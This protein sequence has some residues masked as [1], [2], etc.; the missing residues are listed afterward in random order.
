ML[1]PIRWGMTCWQQQQPV[2]KFQASLDLQ[3][4]AGRLHALRSRS[5][6]SSVDGRHPLP[7]TA[8]SGMA[9]SRQAEDCSLAGL[10]F[11]FTPVSLRAILA[12]RSRDGCHSQEGNGGGDRAPA[13]AAR[14]VAFNL[15]A[16]RPGAS[17]SSPDA[18]KAAAVDGE[19]RTAQS[20]A[21]SGAA[22]GPPQPASSSLVQLKQASLRRR[23]AAAATAAASAP[24]P[25]SS[26]PLLHS[27]TAGPRPSGQPVNALPAWER[28]CT[29]MPSRVCASGRGTDSC[30][31]QLPQAA[32]SNSTQL[33]QTMEALLSG[34]D[35]AV[36][37][38]P[39]PNRPQDRHMLLGR[40][41]LAA[42]PAQAANG[43]PAA[44]PAVSWL[45]QSTAAASPCASGMKAGET[46][47]IAANP[48]L[49]S[50]GSCF[51]ALTEDC[52]A[53][54]APAL[55]AAAAGFDFPASLE[56]ALHCLGLLAPQHG[57][58]TSSCTAAAQCVA[59]A[60]ERCVRLRAVQLAVAAKMAAGVHTELAPLVRRLRQV[61]L[62][63]EFHK[64]SGCLP[65]CWTAFFCW[66]VRNVAAAL[67][68]CNLGES[69]STHAAL[70]PTLC[71]A[72]LSAGEHPA[73]AQPQPTA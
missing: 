52:T 28:E 59:V 44:P 70:L 43:A 41:L 65:S 7:L 50:S 60:D 14:V 47:N 39:A 1:R 67:L 12:P 22:L 40:P 72:S 29:A 66:P 46:G 37:Q 15:R 35:A 9:K 2:S 16:R 32:D 68:Q 54:A 17:Y 61:R 6:H 21:G 3:G 19:Q 33:L 45:V 5:I 71:L 11:S 23:T 49:P 62:H 13:P 56:Q 42:P 4:S 34:C 8:G 36:L 53:A 63:L 48:L 27:E 38:E 31:A 58:G 24:P 57:A 55:E 64:A 26:P 20:R 73:C 25:P 30:S 18:Q 51:G 69:G 10:G